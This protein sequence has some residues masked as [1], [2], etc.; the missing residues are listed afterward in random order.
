MKQI[1][2][3][4]LICTLF[5]SQYGRFLSY[6]ECRISRLVGQDT[7]AP[8][9]C[10]QLLSQTLGEDARDMPVART[11]PS[12]FDEYYLPAAQWMLSVQGGLHITYPAARAERYHPPFLT[13]IFR[14]PRT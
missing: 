12:D 9:D 7:T 11:T 2:A 5:L 8:C 10:Q 14:P 1:T 4:L 6:M 3:I 13:G